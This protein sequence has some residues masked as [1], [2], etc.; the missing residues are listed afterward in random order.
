MEELS[1]AIDLYDGDILPV[2]ASEYE[3]QRL[4]R[5]GRNNARLGLARLGLG[6]QDAMYRSVL[7]IVNAYLRECNE[8]DCIYNEAR[9]GR[10]LKVVNNS[11]E[12]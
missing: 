10:H 6:S 1:Y 7:G 9:F 4:Q 8:C 12:T 5:I 11:G 3:L 2:Y